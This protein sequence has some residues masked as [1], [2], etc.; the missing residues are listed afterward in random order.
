MIFAN[1]SVLDIIPAIIKRIAT[2]ESG[3]LFTVKKEKCIHIAPLGPVLFVKSKRPK[4]LSITIKPYKIIRVAVPARV[5]FKK[6]REYLLSKLDWI[7]KS[8]EYVKKVEQQHES[9]LNGLPKIDRTEARDIIINKLNELSEKHGFGYNRV[10]IR[11]QR[12]RWGS[13]S[14]L[15]NISLNM[16]LVRLKPEL[17]E[18]IILHELVHTRIKSH[19][20][21]FWSELDKY[22]RNAKQLDKTLNKH[23]L[24]LC[25]INSLKAQ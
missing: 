4:R 3:K 16:N 7:K 17:M 22:V 21:K 2:E 1:I 8:L 13:C 18:Y 6:A 23:R 14:H 25:G 5:S 12:T 11:N 15:N 10:Y 24:G 9:T 19:C 20:K